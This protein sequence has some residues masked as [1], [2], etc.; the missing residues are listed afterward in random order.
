MLIQKILILSTLCSI[1]HAFSFSSLLGQVRKEPKVQEVV[2]KVLPEPVRDLVSV[3]QNR[4]WFGEAGNFPFQFESRD[5]SESNAWWLA[6][7][8]ALAY[9]DFSKVKEVMLEQGYTGF[10]GFSGTETDAQAFVAWNTTHA[11][12]VFRGTEPVSY[13]DLLTDARFRLSPWNGPGQVHQGFR[14]A[15]AELEQAGDLFGFL[16]S[17]GDMP[18]FVAGHSMGGAL[19]TLAAARI[20]YARAVYT[21][22]APRAGD[23]L[24]SEGLKVPQYR[25]VNRNDFVVDVPPYVRGL[26]TFDHSGV[27]VLMRSDD[28]LAFE[29]GQPKRAINLKTL[30][31]AGFRKSDRQ[32]LQQDLTQGVY[33][34]LPLN[35]AD[36]L[37][38]TLVSGYTL[39]P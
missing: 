31:T 23:R 3:P 15:I 28:R 10:R 11:F 1:N 35:Y 24:F 21:F 30:F 7:A 20:P 18:L 6:E 4:V 37:A 27:G 9:Q 25:L 12:V 34:H 5:F 17:L 2:S 16:A 29:Q 38:R 8:S 13:Q 19:A 33:D 39:K 22:G 36:S 26:H 32:N 14:D